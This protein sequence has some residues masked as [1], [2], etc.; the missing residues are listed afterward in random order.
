[1]AQE[2]VAESIGHNR[3]LCSSIEQMKIDFTNCL[4]HKQGLEKMHEQSE[5]QKKVMSQEL[6]FAESQKLTQFRFLKRLEANN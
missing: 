3:Q 5:M 6:D 2:K 1:M 4:N